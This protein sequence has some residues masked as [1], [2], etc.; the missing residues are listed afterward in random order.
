MN[1]KAIKEVAT[2]TLHELIRKRWSPRAFSAQPIEAA[3]MDTILQAASWAPS[4]LNEQPWHYIVALRQNTEGFQRLLNC[5][6]PANALWA[7]HAGALVLCYVRTTHERDGK[8]NSSAQHDAGLANANLLIQALSM[9]IY[10]HIMAGFD[11]EK[12]AAAFNLPSTYVPAYMIALGH[13]GNADELAEPFK[14][15]EQTPRSRKALHE[16]VTPA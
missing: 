15:R 5:L 6:N 3:Q 4:A 1:T 11:K 10:G 14:T 16:F 13:L 9:D 7:K 2:E 12:A 8:E